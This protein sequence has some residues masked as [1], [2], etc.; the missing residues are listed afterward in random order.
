[1]SALLAKATQGQTLTVQLL[2]ETL[3]QTMEF[4]SSVA[5]KFGTSVSIDFDL[6]C[7]FPHLEKKMDDILRTMTSPAA[8][9]INSISSSFE[10]HIG[11]YIDAQ[12]KYVPSL[13]PRPGSRW[14]DH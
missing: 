7:T 12:D 10:A 11:V 3:Q 1:M 6:I 14:S 2:L 13:Q 5:K 4:E 8:K 9:P